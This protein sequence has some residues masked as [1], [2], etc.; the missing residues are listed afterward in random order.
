M[1]NVLQDK[2]YSLEDLGFTI[3]EKGKVSNFSAEKFLGKFLL[4]HKVVMD[5]ESRYYMFDGIFWKEYSEVEMTIKYKKFLDSFT[6]NKWKSNYEKEIAHFMKLEVKRIEKMNPYRYIMPFKDFDFDFRAGGMMPKDSERY[7]T[8]VKDI[9]ESDLEEQKCPVFEKMINNISQG[10][11]D[12][13]RYLLQMC[14]ILLSGEN[15]KNLIFIIYGSGANS[16]SIFAK[17]LEHMIGREFVASRKLESFS[18]KYGIGGLENKKLITCGESETTKPINF[19]MIKAITGNDTV[20]SELKHQNIKSVELNLNFLF[21]TNKL[22]KIADRSQGAQRRL[23]LLNFEYQIPENERDPEIFEK[24][25]NE[26]A[27]IFKLILDSY[28]EMVSEEGEMNFEMSQNVKEFTIK[29]INNY[30][31]S[32]EKNSSEEKEK[33]IQ[34]LNEYFEQGIGTDKII[35]SKVHDLFCSEVEDIASETFWKFIKD[36][37]DKMNVVTKRNGERFLVGIKIRDKY[38]NKMPTTLHLGV[39]KANQFQNNNDILG[40]V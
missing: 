30:L 28:C 18:D 4:D 15:R 8:Y 13:R 25:K 32:F 27:G 35:K 20:Q 26:K 6:E 7:F 34:F 17:L 23:Q 21:L 33:C 3:G 5:E 31:V 14:G 19:S 38:N 16:K 36:E 29:Y 2:L 12:F 40:V 11:L 22:Q 1:Q 37:L 24:L 9:S 10:D 39:R